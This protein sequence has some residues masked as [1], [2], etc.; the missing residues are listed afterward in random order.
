MP[1]SRDVV[2]GVVAVD[3]LQADREWEF[4]QNLTAPPAC[5]FGDA[6]EIAGEPIRTAYFPGD[7]P[8]IFETLDM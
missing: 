5:H 4:L 8:L 7:E 6:I 3:H 1:F 2:G